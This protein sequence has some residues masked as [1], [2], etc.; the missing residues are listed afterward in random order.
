MSAEESSTRKRVSVNQLKPGVYVAALDRSWFKTRFYFHRRMIKDAK[1]IELL[2]KYGISEVVIDTT[3][4][5]DVEMPPSDSALDTTTAVENERA[6]ETAA[7]TRPTSLSDAAFR[8]LAKELEAARSIHAEAL[9]AAQKIFD[10]VG[11]G[12]GINSPAAKEVVTNLLDSVARS[13]E[14]NLLLT[15]MHRFQND[16]FTHAVNVCVISLVVATLEQLENDISALGLGALLHD[17]GKTRLPR[18]L[19]RRKEPYTESE[20]QLL[21][22]HP[23]LGTLVLTQS[24]NIPELTSRIVAEHH[25]RIDGSGY[26]KG[27]RGEEISIFSQIVGITDSYEAMLMGRKNAPLQPIEILRQLYLLGN[28]G[29]FDRDLIERIIRCLGVYPAGT[30]VELNT[31]E[32]A[33][34]IAANRVDSLRPILRVI[35]SRDG[36]ALSNGPIISLADAPSGSTD[37]RIVRALDPGKERINLLTHLK[38]ASAFTG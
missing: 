30:L 2:K 19:I 32:R 38:F 14:A 16:L 34:V 23:Q 36:L 20:R 33:I 31:G 10:G 27:I 12:A 7:E 5:A 8:P 21:E 9:A 28:A 22:Q 3:R 29:A 4:G 11:S 6:S 1:Q 25:E 13:P 37:R 35:S 24:E 17:I 15:Q 26:P 18:S